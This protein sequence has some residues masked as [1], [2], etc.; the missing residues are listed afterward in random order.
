MLW[1]LPHEGGSSVALMRLKNGAL[2]TR[3]WPTASANCVGQHAIFS[4]QAGDWGR[5]GWRSPHSSPGAASQRGWGVRAGGVALIRFFAGRHVTCVASDA[6]GGAVGWKR[7]GATRRALW[8]GRRRVRWAACG[9]GAAAGW[10]AG[11]RSVSM[12]GRLTACHTTSAGALPHNTCPLP[13]GTQYT[14]WTS[15]GG[16][17][18]GGC[19]GVAQGEKDR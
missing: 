4:A 1:R 10:R 17:V 2:T 18:D 7:H 8:R 12:C 19:S 11:A 9:G 14:S 13:H 6:L 3:S 16:Q 15:S 5:R